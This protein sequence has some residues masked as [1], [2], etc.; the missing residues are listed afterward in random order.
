M[1]P[2]LTVPVAA[3]SLRLTGMPQRCLA[4]YRPMATVHSVALFSDLDRDNAPRS[5]TLTFDAMSLQDVSS[6]S[7]SILDVAESQLGWK[8]DRQPLPSFREEHTDSADS[9][10]TADDGVRNAMPLSFSVLE[11]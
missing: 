2:L 6:Y 1:W 8:S 11:Q 10:H 7:T 9:F 3:A 4:E 5:T